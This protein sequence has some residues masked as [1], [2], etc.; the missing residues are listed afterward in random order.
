VRQGRGASDPRTARPDAEGAEADSVGV[1]VQLPEHGAL[2]SVAASE[3]AEG[4]EEKMV[5]E[6]AA[7]DLVESGA[8]VP[9]TIDEGLVREAI[10]EIR[11]RMVIGMSVAAHGVGE[12]LLDTFFDGDPKK[13]RT[14]DKDGSPS[15]DALLKHPDLERLS[16]SRTGLYDCV[17]VWIQYQEL[18]LPGL[19]QLPL[20]HQVALLPAPAKVK[21]KLVEAAIEQGMSVRALKDEVGKARKKNRGK[22]KAGRPAL[23]VFVK[24]IH[25]LGKFMK[26]P[27]GSFAD[28]EKI[29]DLDESQAQELYRTVTAMKLQCEKLQ[30]ELQRKVPGFTPED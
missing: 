13:Y 23:P 3:D 28:L 17:R 11:K 9:A 30:K 24:S 8:Q 2:R 22:N 12:Y 29:D 14:R 26:D 18:G 15:F 6:A 19:Q 20:S 25:A 16:L 10:E 27:E 21:E 7:A 5:D 4:R 1:V